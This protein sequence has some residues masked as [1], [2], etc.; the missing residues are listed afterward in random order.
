M[1]PLDAGASAAVSNAQGT[2]ALANPDGGG[3]GD[4]LGNTLVASRGG[5]LASFGLGVVF[6]IGWTPC[7]GIILGGVLTLAATNGRA[8]EGAALL[9]AYTA[10]LGLPFILMGVVY[11]RAPAIVR[12]LVR[13]GRTVSF[14]GGMLVALIGVAM[15]LDLLTLLPRYVQFNTGV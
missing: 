3:M 9:L 5:W 11:D 12:P 13:H 10:G 4:R 8:L 6:A 2:L 14:V 15:L 7:I 1:A